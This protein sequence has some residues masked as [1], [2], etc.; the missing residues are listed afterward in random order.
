MKNF[1]FYSPTRVFFGKEQHLRVGEIIKGY[2]FR[3]VML[4]YG[5]GSIKQSG[6]YDAV[7]EALKREDIRVVELGGAQPNPTLGLVKRGIAM[8]RESGVD[9]VLAV[10]GGSAIDSAKFIAVGAKNDEDPWLFAMKKAV[11]KAALPIAT[12]LTLAAT[13]SEMS[14]SAVITN[15]ELKLKRG[16]GSDFNRPLFSILNPELTYT[17]PP[18]QTACGV[19]DIM[20]HTLERYMTQKSVAE[21]TD[22]I[23]EA[24]LKT[25]IG[26]GR[27]AM[28]NPNDYEARA[29]LMWAGSISHNDLTGLGRDF[30]MVSHQLEHEMSGMFEEVAHGAGLAV[31]FP[32]W[33]KFACRH[34]LER[35][36]RYAVNVWNIEM[37]FVHP[38]NTALAGIEATADF[39]R[40]LGMPSTLRELGIGAE[41]IEEMAVK[42]TNYGTRTLPGLME[43]GK[44][45][46]MEIFKICQ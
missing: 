25:V 35:F 21:M 26:A 39:F 1:E 15:D 6:L 24:V 42:C 46:I 4:H 36:C 8:C 23:A 43:Y 38:E 3:N 7:M 30:F 34:Y 11:P 12:I 33:A 2:G 41:S 28:K 31:V 37:D 16:Y 10:G 14:S 32:A 27:A 40:S 13:G 9:L 29:N 19:V 18:Y 17:L 20:M 45:E 22:R 5:G 44:N